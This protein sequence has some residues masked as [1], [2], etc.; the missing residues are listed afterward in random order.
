MAL[1]LG[2][3]GLV[4]VDTV[5]VPAASANVPD[6]HVDV[7]EDDPALAAMGYDAIPHVGDSENDRGPV[8]WMALA[9]LHRR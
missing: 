3:R 7:V 9:R 6:E 4:L 8:S 5:G 2:S 1:K